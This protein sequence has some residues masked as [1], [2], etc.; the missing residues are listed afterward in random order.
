MLDKL[1]DV[2]DMLAYHTQQELNVL[3]RRLGY[4]F[5]VALIGIALYVLVFVKIY[6]SLLS[7]EFR[8]KE[9]VFGEQFQAG[10]CKLKVSRAGPFN[11]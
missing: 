10:Y 1:P 9:K 6:S 11:V 4:I 3:D 7:L 5:Y 2:D 8:D